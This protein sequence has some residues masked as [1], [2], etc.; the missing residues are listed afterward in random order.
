[1]V[2]KISGLKGVYPHPSKKGKWI[3]VVTHDKKRYVEGPFSSKMEAANSYDKMKLKF[4]PHSQS[5]NNLNNLHTNRIGNSAGAGVGAVNKIHRHDK[6]RV[7]AP[8]LIHFY[9]GLIKHDRIAFS[10]AFRQQF[11]I[12]RNRI[13]DMCN[14]FIVGYFEI[15]H[16]LPLSLYGSNDKNNLQLLCFDCHKFKSN[17]LDKMVEQYIR[18]N[19]SIHSDH[20]PRIQRQIL[21]I[22]RLEKNRSK[23]DKDHQNVR[24]MDIDG[25]KYICIPV[26]SIRSNHPQNHAPLANTRDNEVDTICISSESDSNSVIHVVDTESSSS[27]Y[28]IE[29][30]LDENNDENDEEETSLEMKI[31]TDFQNKFNE[32]KSPL[33]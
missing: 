17:H 20:L 3:A 8:S 23:P 12:D 25:E 13:C 14:K 6:V 33:K 2:S 32:L 22:Q 29:I 9:N 4:F 21:E 19:P 26:N 30:V 1:M 10:T 24:M 31:F 5:L 27:D 18:S 11:C 16:I 15:D 28:S 7:S